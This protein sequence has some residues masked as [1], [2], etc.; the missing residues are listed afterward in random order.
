MP[1]GVLLTHWNLCS[2]AV[3]FSYGQPF[4][5]VRASET[6]TLFSYLP[7][8]HIYQRVLELLVFLHGGAIG[9]FTGD[10]LRLIEDCQVLRPQL[11]PA[12]P[13]ILNR[14]AAGVNATANAPGIKGI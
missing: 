14:I 3:I 1:K 2:G 12:V 11:F 13:R 5:D 8:A 7:L 6:P 4:A 10:P 9:Y